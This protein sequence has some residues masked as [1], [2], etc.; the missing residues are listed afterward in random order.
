MK[1]HRDNRERTVE[2]SDPWPPGLH[3]ITEAWALMKTPSLGHLRLVSA[4][5]GNSPCAA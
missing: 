3:A 2:A 5:E 4:V 1:S